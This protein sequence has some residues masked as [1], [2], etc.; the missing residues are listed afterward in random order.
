MDIFLDSRTKAAILTK[1]EKN[2][3][4]KVRMPLKAKDFLRI[5]G[6]FYDYS[7]YFCI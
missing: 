6:S 3:A 4:P 5:N 7:I 2:T 1:Y